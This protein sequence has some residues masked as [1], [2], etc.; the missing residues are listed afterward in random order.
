MDHHGL[1]VKVPIVEPRALDWKPARSSS[2]ILSAG[3]EEQSHCLSIY[4]V[5]LVRRA[6]SLDHVQV[7]LGHGFRLGVEEAVQRVKGGIHD[8]LPHLDED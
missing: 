1:S 7:T 4:V 3:I 8:R 2:H 6:E 5:V